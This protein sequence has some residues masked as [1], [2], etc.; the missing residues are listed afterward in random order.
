MAAIL[1]LLLM[2]ITS[3]GAYLL[4]ARW[5]RLPLA[6]LPTAVGH[7]MECV[8]LCVVFLVI[9][10]AIG[11]TLVLV[12]RGLSGQFVSVYFVND[13][14]LVLISGLQG[15]LFWSWWYR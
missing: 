1:I 12:G 9:N 3:I 15:L 5:L 14:T 10:V 8:G 13:V 2:C 11:V 6:D 4:G 7:A